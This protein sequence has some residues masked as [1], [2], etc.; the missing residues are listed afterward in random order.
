MGRETRAG[1]GRA[2]QREGGYL[3]PMRGIKVEEYWHTGNRMHR[4]STS[5]CRIVTLLKDSASS[6]EPLLPLTVKLSNMHAKLLRIGVQN[7][8][9]SR[10]DPD[11]SNVEPA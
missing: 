4:T 6:D 3:Q 5:C 9:I 10:V 1:K 11:M 8:I 7:L 2:E